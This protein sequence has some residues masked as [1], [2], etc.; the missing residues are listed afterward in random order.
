MTPPRL[1]LRKGVTDLVVLLISRRQ[2][3]QQNLV[4]VLDSR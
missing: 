4:S 2:V 3:E 1:D